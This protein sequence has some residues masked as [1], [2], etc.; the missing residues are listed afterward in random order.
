MSDERRDDEILGRALARAI[1]TLDVNQ[2]PFERSRVA[3]RPT[4][5]EWFNVWNFAGIA[6]TLLVVAAIGAYVLSPKDTPGT[7]GASPTGSAVPSSSPTSSATPSPTTTPI[8]TVAPGQID[9]YRV[10]FARDGLP[11][12][13]AHIDNAGIGQTAADRIASRASALVG[14]AA[15]SGATNEA[16][17]IARSFQPDQGLVVKASVNG[18][19]ATVDFSFPG[20]DWGA[21]GSAQSLA[22]EQQLVYTITEEPGI[23]RA[24]VTTN[25]GRTTLDQLVW[26][27]PLAREDVFGYSST[28]KPGSS[29]AIGQGGNTSAR[30]QFAVT[31]S[32]DSVAPGLARVVLTFKDAQGGDVRE[33]P[34]FNATLEQSDDA[35]APRDA[36]YAMTI[37]LRGQLSTT[38]A[39]AVVDRTPLRAVR[40]EGT[41]VRIG[42]DDARPWRLF[43]LTNPARIV[44]DVGGPIA[45]TSDRVA[46]YSPRPGATVGRDL[47]LTGAARVY[48][49]NVNWRLKNSAGNVVADGTFMT[50]GAGIVW[51][52]F[53]THITIPASV[54]GN[55]TLEVFEAS[56]QD[57]RPLGTVA[58]PLTVR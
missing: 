41:T 15:P 4:K 56:A 53:D 24:I 46:V 6:A 45:A 25:G 48:E 1:E 12:T 34:E 18:D 50:S 11:P 30:Y 13:S 7:V 8:A 52:T 54:T 38:S 27:T 22:L 3:N 47:Q 57:G 49:A 2:T 10:Y 40:I 9:H 51:G 23:R 26:D 39:N 14:A 21:R 17:A 32:V 36:K 31:N 33:L 35:S 44:V 37:A 16:S 55:V 42:L 29:G 5:Q 58:I 28:A 43:T 20:G 19:V